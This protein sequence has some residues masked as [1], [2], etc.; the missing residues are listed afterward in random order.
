ML[1]IALQCGAPNAALLS[2]LDP[3]AG[4]IVFQILVAGVVSSGVL[5]MGAFT[6]IRSKLFGSGRR[7]GNATEEQTEQR[8]AA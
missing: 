6:R 8:K 4:S 7:K 5:L 3:G 1:T 2:Y